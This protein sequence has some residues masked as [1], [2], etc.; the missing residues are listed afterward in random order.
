MSII[1]L[2]PVNER[3]IRM[4]YNNDVI[5]FYSDSASEPAYCDI[6]A[7]GLDV[8]LYP[9]PMGN[10]FFNFR[11][12]IS[13]LINTQNFEDTI[14]A[15][16]YTSDPHTFAY[17]YTSAIYLEKN[18]VIKIVDS[19]SVEDQASYNLKWI[20][21]AEQ[22]GNYSEV[23]SQGLF[24]LSPLATV[25]STY[26]KYWQGYP[27]DIP[28]YSYESEVKISNDTNLLEQTF[29]ELNFV[30]RLFVSDGRTDETL[31]DLLPLMEGHNNIVVGNSAHKFYLTLEK[32]PYTCG[33]YLK[34]LNKYGGYNYWL[35]ED[36]F[37]VDRSLKNIGELS[38]DND[39]IENSFARTLQ[40]G[41]ESQDIMRLVAE[42]LTEEE[43]RVVEGIFDSPKIYLFT[44]KPFAR[45]FPNSWTEVSLRTS[46]VRLKNAK[47]PLTNFVIDIELPQRYTQTL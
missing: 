3:K 24:V 11:P 17:D 18:V 28:F 29:S 25:D 39:N 47:H 19:N 31:E 37:S 14:V 40:I 44:G 27:F 1:H 43:R 42:L 21:G 6:I 2:K 22:I 13:A 33:A 5:R 10:F 38:S 26:L 23:D 45:A 12:Y 35:F 32:V 20:A 15:G 36:T 34:W 16:L 4:A 46:N 41:K 8:R 30:T 7:N 9:D